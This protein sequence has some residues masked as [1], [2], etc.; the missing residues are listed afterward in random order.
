MTIQLEAQRREATGTSAVRRLR[1]EGK[2]PG[3]I[4]GQGGDA[5][6]ITVPYTVF[7]K[8]Y[9]EAGETTIIDV[10]I[11]GAEGDKAVVADVQYDPVKHRISHVD[12]HRVNMKEKITVTLPLHLV[13]ESR[14]IKEEGGSL[15]HAISELDIR[16][17]PSDLIHSID[18]DVSTIT[19]F[20]DVITIADLKLPSTIEI[21]GHEPE[22]VVVTAAEAKEEVEEAPA[23]VATEADA[24][25]QPTEA[26]AQSAEQAS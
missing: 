24:A 8:L 13:G 25:G 15:I 2:I 23:P 16:C 7:E 11:D 19:S 17:L 18:V 6:S 4:Y 9:R 3:V 20:G 10:R 21:V 14:I 26:Q 12:F 22:E 1:D 5:Q